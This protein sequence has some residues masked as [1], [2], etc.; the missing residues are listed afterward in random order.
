MRMIIAQIE[1]LLFVTNRPMSIKKIAEVAD[2]T[3]AE[4]N[5]AISALTEKYSLPESGLRLMCHGDDVQLATSPECSEIVQQFLKEET[6][7]E[8]TKA[9]L[10]TLTIVAY[11]GPLTKA[12][13][14]QIRGVNCTIILRNLMMRGLVESKGDAKDA[15][16]TYSVT[17]EFIRFLGVTEVGDLPDY[18]RLR[19][20]DSI[21]SVLKKSHDV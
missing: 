2:A 18:E 20:H 6:T 15:L 7:G 17:T 14:E 3:L 12:E 9:S 8:L 4:V 11:R 1:A 19:S 21:V 13:L 5:D 16:T 10:E